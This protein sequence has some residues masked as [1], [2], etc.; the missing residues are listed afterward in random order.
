[1]FWIKMFCHL[2]SDCVCIQTAFTCGF[3]CSISDTCT[4]LW[5]WSADCFDQIQVI[6]W[7][8]SLKLTKNISREICERRLC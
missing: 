1:M 5:C 3:G 8:T 7:V 2:L 4:Q 6:R